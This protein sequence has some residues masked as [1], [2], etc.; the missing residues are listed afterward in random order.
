MD[1][2][3]LLSALLSASDCDP[4]LS[5]LERFGAS[6]ADCRAVLDRQNAVIADVRAARIWLAEVA[7]SD[8]SLAAWWA[9]YEADL[10]RLQR[11][12]SLLELA[13]GA[14]RYPDRTTER[15][16]R[17]YLGRLRGLLGDEWYYTGCMPP[18]VPVWRLPYRE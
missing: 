11:P 4:P 16:R 3:L 9:G 8:V 12:W 17:V 18:A 1:A 14:S 5:D 2:L 7:P 13:H 6:R 15:G 10:H